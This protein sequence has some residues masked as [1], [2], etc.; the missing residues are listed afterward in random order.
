M[1]AINEAL[2]SKNASRA[3]VELMMVSGSSA[4]GKG[5]LLKPSMSCIESGGS[6]RDMRTKNCTKQCRRIKSFQVLLDLEWV[7]LMGMN[8][9][10]VWSSYM[11]GYA[12]LKYST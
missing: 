9:L 6:S 2:T 8:K 10:W 11:P 5:L 4:P 7:K 12:F 3:Q 1:H